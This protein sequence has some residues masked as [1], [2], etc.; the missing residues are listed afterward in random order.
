MFR[1]VCFTIL[2]VFLLLPVAV[3]GED[4]IWT[5]HTI[6]GHFDGCSDVYAV[7]L[8][9][10]GDMDVLGAGFNTDDIAWWENDG[11]Q[12]FTKHY[13]DGDF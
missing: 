9:S 5:E 10:D 8:D 13:I 4:I 6:D 11:Y 7:D 3:F 1:Q 12:N 2:S